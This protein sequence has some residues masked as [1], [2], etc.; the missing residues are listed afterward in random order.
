MWLGEIV[1][2][3]WKVAYNT[4]DPGRGPFRQAFGVQD[5]RKF[6]AAGPVFTSPAKLDLLS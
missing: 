1:L 5:F 3:G 2:A 4:V 6:R